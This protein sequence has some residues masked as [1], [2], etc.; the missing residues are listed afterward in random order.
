[1]RGL[2]YNSSCPKTVNAGR[3][4]DTKRAPQLVFVLLFA[5]LSIVSSGRG[6]SSD[7]AL[8]PSDSEIP[9]TRL[10]REPAG[11]SRCQFCHASEVEGYAR[12]AMAHSLRRA[13]QEPDGTVETPEARITMYSSPTGY[14][15]RLQSGGDVT[16]YRI[17]YVIGSGNH[18]S[19]YLLDLAGHLFQSPVAY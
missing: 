15:Q 11:A 5:G 8:A 14:W 3:I 4:R 9:T 12:S 7:K 13:G 10:V 18:A 16:S 17:D 2:R 6:Q 1:L 19:G